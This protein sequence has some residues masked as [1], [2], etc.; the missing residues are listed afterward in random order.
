MAAP[1]RNFHFSIDRGGTFTDVFAEVGLGHGRPGV[2]I[3]AYKISSCGRKQLT[4]CSINRMLQVPDGAGRSTFK[5][6][7]REHGRWAAPS[8]CCV[9][10]CM[11]GQCPIPPV[12]LCRVLKL[13]SEDPA[14]YPDAPREGIR[15]VLEEVTGEEPKSATPLFPPSGRSGHSHHGGAHGGRAPAGVPH[16]R[17][18]PLDT[19]RIASIRMGTTVATNALLE[20]KGERVALLVTQGFPD[21][22]HIANQVSTDLGGGPWGRGAAATAPVA[23]SGRPV[24]SRPLTHLC[25]HPLPLAS[26]RQTRRR[27]GGGLRLG[28]QSWSSMSPNASILSFC[29]P[30]FDIYVGIWAMALAGCSP[31]LTFLTS[32]SAPRTSSTSRW[33]H[34]RGR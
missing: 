15:R 20:R 2:S 25:T 10:V 19:S 24:P 18:R 9:P 32:R 13:L 16:P 7:G 1:E 11:A 26:A 33:G 30:I 8:P 23:T 14:N 17:D 29:L 34:V 5:W 21:L 22:L 4:S 28:S 31:G 6:V 12:A 27:R 3:W